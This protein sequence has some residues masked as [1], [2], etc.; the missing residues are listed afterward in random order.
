MKNLLPIVLMLSLFSCGDNKV[1]SRTTIIDYAPPEE[2]GPVTDT[3]ITEIKFDSMSTI[4]NQPSI[5][6]K[7]NTASN[8]DKVKIFFGD[9]IT[10]QSEKTLSEIKAGYSLTLRTNQSNAIK[11]QLEKEGVVISGCNSIATVI[12]DNVAPTKNTSA[13]FSA[14]SGESSELSFNVGGLV[15][16]IDDDATEVRY[17]RKEGS[18]FILIATGTRSEFIAKAIT[19]SLVEEYT[20]F[21]T[22]EVV[23]GAGNVS[24]KSPYTIIIQTVLGGTL[25]KPVLSE[26]LI[27]IND[28][29]TGLNVVTLKGM[30]SFQTTSVEVYADALMSDL[31]ATIPVNVFNGDGLDLPLTENAPKSYFLKAIA[32]GKSSGIVSFSSTYDTIAPDAPVLDD[33]F[34]F[35][36]NEEYEQGTE[37]GFHQGELR[38]FSRGDECRVSAYEDAE[39]TI[40]YNTNIINTRYPT[41]EEHTAWKLAIAIGKL[42]YNSVYV[43]V[44]DCA[45]NVSLPT[46]RYFYVIPF[47]PE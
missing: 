7:A 34:Y 46:L 5:L 14:L 11:Y 31:V 2:E 16:E 13:S 1:I 41:D 23:D 44:E 22:Y 36:T 17:Y 10:E 24:D 47:E 33:D 30:A 39:L 37:D 29:F 18:N 45:G 42:G 3:T 4:T 21:L 6:I 26:E 9:C 20:N 19:I 8:F 35:K 27:A 43:V 28:W 32:D 15:T 38:G 12:H 25:P 40:Q